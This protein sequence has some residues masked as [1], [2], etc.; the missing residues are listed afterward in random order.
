MIAPFATDVEF[1]YSKGIIR[2]GYVLS[3]TALGLSVALVWSILSFPGGPT[4]A[5]LFWGFPILAFTLYA[6]WAIPMRFS[7]IVLTGPKLR[8]R[9]WGRYWREFT[10][11]QNTMVREYEFFEIIGRNSRSITLKNGKR[12]FTFDDSLGRYD[13]LKMAIISITI[14]SGGKI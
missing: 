12:S 13:D 10:I 9:L 6:A 4:I 8:R 5:V 3:A 11:D 14:A 1:F 2:F 7:T